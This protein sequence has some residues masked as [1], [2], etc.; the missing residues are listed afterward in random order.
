MHTLHSFNPSA[1]QFKT[2][3]EDDGGEWVGEEMRGCGTGARD[4]Y[5]NLWISELI[6]G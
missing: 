5:L 6:Y 4:S 2:K 1:T 3:P